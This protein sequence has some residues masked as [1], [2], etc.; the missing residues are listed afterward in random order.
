M[1]FSAS[2]SFVAG[3]ALSASGVATIRMTREKAELP[4]AMIPFLFGIQQITEGFVWLSFS[5]ATSTFNAMSTFVYSLFSHVLWPIYVP[6]AV[7]MIDKVPWRRRVLSAFQIIGLMV[8]LY[9]LYYMV[10]SPITSSVV[11]GR[12]VYNSPHF[13]I[14]LIM[15]FYLLSTCISAFFSSHKL[16]RLFGSMALALALLTYWLFSIAFVSVWC[17]FAAILSLI[18]FLHF[19]NRK[20]YGKWKLVNE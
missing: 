10:T 11:K 7:R 12:I 1:C 2:A 19:Y 14:V 13:Y 5:A 18:I 6:F 4:L 17:F 8:G 9:L 15:I 16:I 3:T 20:R